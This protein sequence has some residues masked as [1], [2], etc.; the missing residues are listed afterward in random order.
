MKYVFLTGT[1][2]GLGEATA[3]MFKDSKI[4]SI[5]RSSVEETGNIHK[6]FSVDFNDTEAMEQFVPEIFNSVDPDETDEVYLLNIAGIVDPVKAVSN[7]SAADMMTNYKVNVIAPTLLIK[8]FI[9]RF[10]SFSGEKRI[11]TVTSGAAR[12]PV[13]GWSV[14]CSSKAA[15]NMV[16][17]VLSKENINQGNNIKSAVFYPGVIDTGMQETIRASDIKEFPNVDRFKEYKESNKLAKAEDVA[18]ALHKVVTLENFGNEESYDVKD[19][20]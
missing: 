2:R 16:H 5:T 7:L 13:E 20:I 14:Y 18:T 11:V 4:I 19:Y 12:G 8:G 1:N 9:N 15:V 10:K 3:N 6:A 17:S